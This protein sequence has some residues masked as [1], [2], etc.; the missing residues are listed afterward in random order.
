MKW[1]RRSTRSLA[2]VVLTITGLAAQSWA[3]DGS[4]AAFQRSYQLEAAGDLRAALEALDK[5]GPA[6]ELQY[7]LRLR[8]AWLNYS[9]GDHRK[10]IEAY[11]LASQR[12][13]L[14]VEPL[15]GLTLPQI[16]LRLWRDAEQT[17][18]R[19]LKLDPKNYLGQSRLAWTLYNL[20]R[21][22]EAEAAYAAVLAGYPADV[23]MRAGLGWALLKQSKVAQARQEFSFILAI[24]PTHLS[25]SQGLQATGVPAP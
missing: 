13:P 9:L 24:A 22:Q 23:E 16:A 14:A 10:A 20:G 5:V 8:Q 18:R 12:A 15:L 25:A 19:V 6:Q 1:K 3:A 11:G 21:Y 17:C 4:P 7:T 2:A